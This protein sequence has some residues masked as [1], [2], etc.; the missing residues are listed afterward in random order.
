MEDTLIQSKEQT[1]TKIID[2]K[3][4]LLDL[5]L[6]DVIRYRDLIW[7]L[8]KRDFAVTYKQ[9]I[10]GPLWYVIQ[11]LISTVLY[12]FIFGNLAEIGTDG[13]PYVL[14]YFAGSMLWTYFSNCLN[15]CST[16]FLD[17]KGV[18][19]KVYFPRLCVPIS[20]TVGHIFKLL[21][22][23][24]CLLVF[25]VY[26]L[27]VGSNVHPTWM[28]AL[29]PVLLLWIGSVGMGLG[30]ICSALTTKYRDLKFLVQFA[31]PLAMYIT[32]VVYPLS[33]APESLSWIFYINPVSAPIEYFRIFFYGAGNVPLN[34]LWISLSELVVIV[35][36]GLVLFN[37]NEKNFVDVI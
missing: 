15:S 1:W 30:L 23:F 9:S 22:Q 19:D 11:P 36:L 25:Y 37:H 6:R 5:K 3:P 21:I 28:I 33:E 7:M 14:F 8:I 16:C 17:N 10:L 12:T 27:I 31:L 26:Y 4:K 2:S 35:F 20:T 29:F 13:V 24:A 18:F 32:P 34:M